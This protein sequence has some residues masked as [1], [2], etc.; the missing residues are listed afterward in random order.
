MPN[1]EVL[2]LFKSKK[3]KNEIIKKIK[4]RLSANVDNKDL[5]W[6]LRVDSRNLLEYINKW[7]N[8]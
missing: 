4:Q 3:T 1:K 2:N 8:E 6:N 5:E 7:E